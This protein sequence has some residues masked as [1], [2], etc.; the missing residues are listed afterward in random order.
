MTELTDE[1]YQTKALDWLER[2]PKAQQLLGTA[3]L[4]T[5]S[6]NDAWDAFYLEVMG[7]ELFRVFDES[8]GKTP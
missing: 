5:E 2:N 1:E 6:A 4:A 8:K 7:P 3:L